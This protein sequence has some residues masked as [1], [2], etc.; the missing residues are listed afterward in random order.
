MAC[1]CATPRWL[2]CGIQLGFTNISLRPCGKQVAGIVGPSMDHNVIM[3]RAGGA[4]CL[5]GVEIDS[6]CGRVPAYPY[7]LTDSPPDGVSFLQAQPLVC[8]FRNPGIT[9][10]GLAFA[11]RDAIGVQCAM[12]IAQRPSARMLHVVRK[13]KGRRKEKAVVVSAG[14]KRRGRAF[15]VPNFRQ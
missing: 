13:K 15:P 4:Y 5:E 2:V 12:S 1:P 8:L 11:S 6:T 9:R 3:A 7:R 14:A 10:P